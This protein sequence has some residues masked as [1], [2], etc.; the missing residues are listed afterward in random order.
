MRLTVEEASAGR[1]I[2][3]FLAEQGAAPSVAAGRR[4]IAAGLVRLDGR[5]PRKG[6][7][8]RPGQL[9][10]THEAPAIAAGPAPSLDV[11]YEDDDLVAVNKPAGVPSQSL[12]PGEIG[13]VA[14]ALVARYP[15]CASA[16][17][18]PRE[19]GLG[20]RLDVGTSGVLLAARHSE[21]WRRLRQALGAAD[22]EKLYLAEVI[23][24]LPVVADGD[25]GDRQSDRVL[26]GDRSEAVVV[27]AAIGRTGRRGKRV[28]LEGG[29]QPLPARTEFR[30]RERRHET[31]VIEARLSKGRAHQVRAHLAH[32]GCPVVGDDIYGHPGGGATLRLHALAVTLRHPI[33]G[34]PLRIEA[35][36][37]GWAVAA[38]GRNSGRGN[39]P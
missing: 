34:G 11:L 19:G 33:T 25:G 21:A 31:S 28:R 17:P 37:P 18:D 22:C 20:H 26:L 23:G 36:L 7:R 4:A 9:V 39:T 35:P 30:L 14:A 32:L 27:T 13:S 3:A 5:V 15:E 16:A 10:E 24:V 1:R 6:M 2:D 12:R 8:V 29:R 38:S